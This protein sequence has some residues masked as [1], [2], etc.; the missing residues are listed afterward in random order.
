MKKDYE[1]F[2]IK[3][4]KTFLKFIQNIYTYSELIL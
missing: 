3:K 1:V 4:N 2:Y